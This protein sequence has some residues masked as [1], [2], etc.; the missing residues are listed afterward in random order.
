MDKEIN[1]FWLYADIEEI[2]DCYSEVDLKE[3]LT[4]DRANSN[5]ICDGLTKPSGRND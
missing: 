3:E 1:L 5:A 2:I 4:N